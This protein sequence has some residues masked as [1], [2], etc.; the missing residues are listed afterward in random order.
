M[1]PAKKKPATEPAQET[2]SAVDPMD[3]EVIASLVQAGTP[4]AEAKAQVLGGA[5]PPKVEDA[6]TEDPEPEPPVIPQK[7]KD[8][9]DEQVKLHNEVMAIHEGDGQGEYDVKIKLPEYLFDWAARRTIIEAA[10]RND[11]SF[12]LEKFLIWMIKQER[13]IDPTKGGKV[14]G[15]SSGPADQYNPSTERWG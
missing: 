5:Q 9:S 6:S 15:G 10:R 4:Y 8:F 11:P 3:A 13:A 12:D 1:A 14:T 7:S 2:A